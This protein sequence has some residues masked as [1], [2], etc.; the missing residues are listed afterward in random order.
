MCRFRLSSC[1]TFLGIPVHVAATFLRCNPNVVLSYRFLFNS[2]RL[3]PEV[4][5]SLRV[6]N[7]NLQGSFMETLSLCVTNEILQG[8]FME[9]LS[10]C[11]TNESLLGYLLRILHGYLNLFLH[12][13]KEIL[14]QG[15]VLC[16][17]L[18]KEIFVSKE[19]LQVSSHHDL[20]S[21]SPRFQ[22]SFICRV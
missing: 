13:T 10:L 19:C 1:C 18:T 17:S 5:V 12:V 15:N 9:T 11:V 14:Y 21:S 22:I 8:S 3:L 6:T 16:M 2:S 20:G 7:E 4:L